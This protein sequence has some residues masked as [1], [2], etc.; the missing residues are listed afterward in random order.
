[1]LLD[2]TTKNQFTA[3]FMFA[4]QTVTNHTDAT[5][6][7]LDVAGVRGAEVLT[8]IGAMAGNDGSNTLVPTLQESDTLVG[9]DFTNVAAA[10]IVGG[11]VATAVAANTVNKQGYLGKKRYIRVKLDFTGTGISSVVVGVIGHVQFATLM[12]GTDPS[13]LMTT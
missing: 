12:P 11:A 4:P 10:D 1:M 5:T 3:P 2:I 7:A 8:I 13:P 9:T 6:D